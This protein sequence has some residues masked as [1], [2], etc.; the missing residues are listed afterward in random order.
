[1]L[2][3]KAPEKMRLSGVLF[4]SRQKYKVRMESST[5]KKNKLL[6]FLNDY[7]TTPRGVVPSGHQKKKVVVWRLLIMNK[8]LIALSVSAIVAL[9]IF[10]ANAEEVKPLST[11]KGFVTANYMQVTHHGFHKG[12]DIAFNNE[13][14]TIA[15]PIDG[16]VEKMVK[17]EDKYYVVITSPT[18]GDSFVIALLDTCNLTMGQVVKAG[19]VV[20]AVKDTPVH[21]EYWVHDSPINPLPILKLNGMEIDCP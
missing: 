16:V 6:I 13:N 19:D 17:D 10:Q 14:T 20:G 11:H 3:L 8:K 1:M 12:V 4:L 9:G 2:I 18:I 21:I 7:F 5:N 15:S